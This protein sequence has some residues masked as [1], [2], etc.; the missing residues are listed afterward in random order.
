ML[1]EGMSQWEQYSDVLLL[2]G[3]VASHHSCTRV[4][5]LDSAAAMMCFPVSTILEYSLLQLQALSCI[6]CASAFCAI[7][8]AVMSPIV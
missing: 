1:V 7:Q 5:V 3:Q 8:A 6:C 4:S 2:P